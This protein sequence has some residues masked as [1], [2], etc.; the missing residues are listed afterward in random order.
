[1]GKPEVY[2]PINCSFYDYLEEAATLK[3]V[4][5]IEYELDSESVKV[6]SLLKTLFIKDKVEYMLLANEQSIRLD[7]LISFNGKPLPKNC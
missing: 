5:V 1:M 2:I 6:E 3:R 7:S 4:S